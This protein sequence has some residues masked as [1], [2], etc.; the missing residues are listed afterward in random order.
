MNTRIISG[1][2][3]CYKEKANQR[4]DEKTASCNGIISFVACSIFISYL[5]GHCTIKMCKSNQSVH[6]FTQL[7]RTHWIKEFNTHTYFLGNWLVQYK[8]VVVHL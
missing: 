1:M 6:G 7:L 2:L 3:L 5:I 4:Q 8:C